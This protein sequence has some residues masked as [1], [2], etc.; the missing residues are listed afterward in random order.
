MPTPSADPSHQKRMPE[1]DGLRGVAIL[2]V[3]FFH[4]ITYSRTHEGNFGRLYHFAQIF[5]LGW[6]GVDLFF[7]L[8]GFLIGG[9]LLDARSSSNYFRTF[10]VRRVHR[11][12]P[13]Y[14]VWI[15]LYALVGYSLLKWGSPATDN[16]VGNSLRPGV[17]FLFLQN[18]LYKHASVFSG[19]WVGPTWSLAVEEQFY[20]LS[21]MVIRFLSPRRLVQ[22]LLASIVAAPVLRYF[23]FSHLSDGVNKAYTLMPCRADALAMGVLA[24]VAWRTAAKTLLLRHCSLLKMIFALLLLGA[25]AM[26]KWMPDPRNAIEAAFQ[27]SWLGLLYTS[28]ILIA[29]L[30]SNGLL[31]RAARWRFLRECGR[32]S[33]CVYLIHSGIVGMRHWIIFR[34]TPH[35]DDWPGFLVTV[36]AAALTWAIALA[37]WRYFE[38]PLLDRGH[39]YVYKLRQNE[40]QVSA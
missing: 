16:F 32:V 4:Y 12:L 33:Y 13:I 29:L 10:Y 14:Y 24:A 27:Y 3:F 15:A 34:A 39:R 26:I 37:S 25:V 28:T 35:I 19:D 5:R 18:I 1:L 22:V 40:A 2:M 30:D 6:S 21:P 7:V 31:A 11:I 36:L 8:S 38:K 17:Y 20:L 23:V 9:I